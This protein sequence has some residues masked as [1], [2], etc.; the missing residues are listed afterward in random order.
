MHAPHI[1]RISAAAE[2]GEAKLLAAVREARRDN[3][4]WAVIGAALRITPQ[5]AEKRFGA[6]AAS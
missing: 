3:L 6:Q 5:A 1:L 2:R 4:P